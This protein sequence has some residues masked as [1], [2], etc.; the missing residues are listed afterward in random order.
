[1]IV[2]WVITYQSSYSY[3]LYIIGSLRYSINIIFQ[4]IVYDA[5][6]YSMTHNATPCGLNDPTTA[7]RFYEVRLIITTI[8]SNIDWRLSF[9]ALH[10][11]HVGLCPFFILLDAYQTFEQLTYQGSVIVTPFI[12]GMGC[13]NLLTVADG[14][15]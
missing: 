2:T 4:G 15:V 7:L 3:D 9:P 10:T 13:S 6:C 11:V 14:A 12:N 8:V 5:I 1:M